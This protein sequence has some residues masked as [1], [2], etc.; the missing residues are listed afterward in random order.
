MR[1]LNLINLNITFFSEP[2]SRLV[3]AC[4]NHSDTSPREG[5][6]NKR[7]TRIQGVAAIITE[8]TIVKVVSQLSELFIG[9]SDPLLF[10]DKSSWKIVDLIDAVALTNGTP[11]LR[12][13][14][15]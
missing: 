1:R 12:F 8:V 10:T 9:R 15:L 3:V 6:A 14:R 2:S 11:C 13:D 5:T 7:L 4:V